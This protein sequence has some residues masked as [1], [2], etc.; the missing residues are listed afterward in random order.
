[1]KSPPPPLSSSVTSVDATFGD[2]LHLTG[3]QSEYRPETQTLALALHWQALQQTDL[4]YYFSAVLVSPDGVALPGVDWQPLG[5][6]Y[7]TS[8][9]PPG[10]TVV[11]QIELPLG[12]DAAAGDWWLSLRAFGIRGDQP[13][14]PL[15]V[16]LPD[17]ATDA[18]LGLGPLRV[19]P[20]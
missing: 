1:M 4:P 3:Y 8:C 19:N 18:Q 11:D 12:P 20:E 15:T 9:W 16:T 7:P 14:P 10:R 2:V 17:G 13:L 6:Q 5:K